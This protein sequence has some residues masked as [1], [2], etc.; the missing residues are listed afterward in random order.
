MKKTILASLAAALIASIALPA[1]A[2]QSDH[3]PRH[4]PRVERMMERFDSNRDGVVTLEDISAHRQEM[5]NAID[6]DK[7]AAL[8]KDELKA[9]GEQRMEMRQKNREERRTERDSRK[10]DMKGKYGD[11][12]GRMAGKHHGERDGKG[13]ADNRGGMQMER[14]DADKNGAISLKEFT[15]VDGKMFERFDR[16]GDN[17]IDITDFYRERADKN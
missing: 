9:F 10:S 12:D 4:G 1:M 13:R 14:L 15:A 11:R 3:G 2:A 7:S 5:F 8:S 6:T 17:K 16:N